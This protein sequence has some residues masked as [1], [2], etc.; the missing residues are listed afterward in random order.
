MEKASGLPYR[1]RPNK[2][3]DRELFAMALSRIL[4]I[5][6][7]AR[8]T[9]IGMGGPFL[10]DF[11]LLHNRLGITKMICCDNDKDTHLRQRFNSPYSFID[12]RHERIENLVAS[13]P[14]LDP[15]ICWLDFTTP[16]ELGKQIEVFGNLVEE[17]PFYSILRI[18]LN[19]KPTLDEDDK[20]SPTGNLDIILSNRKDM[21]M[22]TLG[23]LSPSNPGKDMFMVENYGKLL[24]QTIDRH[25][26]KLLETSSSRSFK[27]LLCTHYADGQPMVTACCIVFERKEEPEVI[28]SINKIF[29][30]WEFNSSPAEPLILDV[31][32][33]SAIE[34][35]FMESYSDA[36]D[37][38]N[39]KLPKSKLKVDPFLS[40]RQFY[41]VYSYYTK[42]DF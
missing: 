3:V 18:T 37:L 23:E 33:L 29:D 24:L 27:W 20:P 1:L 8:Y 16:S 21:F 30:T 4:P 19:A 12:Y 10:D 9:Y 13:M 32:I 11:R 42:V 22:S 41:R 6:E 17:V 35:L 38:M 39:Y 28:Q 40:F 34:K 25:L 15:I 2:A 5:L 36:K 7:C 14:F 31:P 26:K